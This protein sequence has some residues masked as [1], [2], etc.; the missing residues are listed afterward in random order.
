[1]EDKNA[2]YYATRC[3]VMG[4]DPLSEPNPLHMKWIGE[5]FYG[6]IKDSWEE[7]QKTGLAKEMDAKIKVHK[8]E[9]AKLQ[10]E[11]YEMEKQRMTL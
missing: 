3:K 5:L 9:I 8:E 6:R 10:S 7:Y 1:M 2:E 4:I 11:L